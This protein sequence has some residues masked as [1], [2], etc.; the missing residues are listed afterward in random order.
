MN[1]Q[2]FDT[3]TWGGESPSAPSSLAG[4]FGMLHGE[5]KSAA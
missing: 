5:W 2:V 1:S 3:S 4:T